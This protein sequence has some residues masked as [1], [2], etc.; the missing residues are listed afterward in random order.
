M[1]ITISEAL[2]E[3]GANIDTDQEGLKKALKIASK[4]YHPDQVGGSKEKFQRIFDIYNFLNDVYND[5]NADKIREF[6]KI[7]A[8]KKIT[9]APFMN[10]IDS[11]NRLVAVTEKNLLNKNNKEEL[12]AYLNEKFFLKYELLVH[13]Y[14]SLYLN[15]FAE[16]SSSKIIKYNTVND[17]KTD[18][19]NNYELYN[20]SL[21]KVEELIESKI[22]NLMLVDNQKP[23][24]IEMSKNELKKYYVFNIEKAKNKYRNDYLDYNVFNHQR[25]FINNNINNVEK[26][27]DMYIDENYSVLSTNRILDTINFKITNLNILLESSL[28][29]EQRHQKIKEEILTYAKKLFNKKIITIEQYQDFTHKI[30]NAKNT[31]VL[32]NIKTNLENQIYLFKLEKVKLKLSNKYDKWIKL[33]Q[34][35]AP[36]YLQQKTQIMNMINTYPSETFLSF[37]AGMDIKDMEYVQSVITAFYEPN[38][39]EEKSR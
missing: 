1:N 24:K 3:L 32:N 19:F 8:V 25:N 17:I 16:S 31:A 33:N 4:K 35:L 13:Q 38:K 7:Y 37:I 29:N 10:T 9:V 30:N 2:K 11:I 27:L 14:I 18:I 20:M 28:K 21:D 23:L 5:Q 6:D 34:S 36:F 26:E 39:K 22:K 15:K 12:I